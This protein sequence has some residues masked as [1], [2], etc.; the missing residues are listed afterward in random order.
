MGK[1][2]IVLESKTQSLQEVYDLAKVM[3]EG[4]EIPEDVEVF[5]VPGDD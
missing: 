3:V 5:V 2:T 4:A 1:V